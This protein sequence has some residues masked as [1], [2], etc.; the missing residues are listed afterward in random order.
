MRNTTMAFLFC[1]ISSIAH[2]QE[3]IESNEVFRC[4]NSHELFCGHTQRNAS[5]G[6]QISTQHSY[7]I[8]DESRNSFMDHD[9]I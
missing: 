9:R 1:L 3:I 7:N 4:T 2:A 5:L 8:V 6:W